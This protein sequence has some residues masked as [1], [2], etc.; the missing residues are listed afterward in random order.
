MRAVADGERHGRRVRAMGVAGAGAAVIVVLAAGWAFA[1]LGPRVGADN[2]VTPAQLAAS[3]KTEKPKSLACTAQQLTTASGSPK[4]VVTGADPTGKYILGRTYPNGKPQA[5]IW[6]DR[7]PVPVPMSGD[8]QELRD[9]TSTGL[10]VGTSFPS[11]DDKPAAWVYAGGKVTRLSGGVAEANAVNERGM[12]AGVVGNR[13]AMWRS[14]NDKPT[15]LALPGAGWQGRAMGI[16]E[17]GTIVGSVSETGGS[18]TAALWRPDGTLEL[19]KAAVTGG[20][21]TQNPTNGGSRAMSIR[22]GW[23]TIWIA[24][25]GLLLNAATGAIT[26]DA[27]IEAVNRQGWT[28]GDG[29]LVAGGETVK[30]LPPGGETVKRPPGGGHGVVVSAISDDGVTVAGYVPGP[31]AVPV[32]WTCSR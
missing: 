12:I 1:G 17:D 9:A 16:D 10:A 2:T 5:V 18:G 13:P 7:R 14:P 3:E 20:D 6:I 8:D 24:G 21:V 26:G 22:G 25:G 15:M 30:L 32:V 28:A 19:V 11:G 4:G 31:D 23:V 29:R 27:V